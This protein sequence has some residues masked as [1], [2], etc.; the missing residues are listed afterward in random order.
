MIVVVKNQNQIL[1]AY[2]QSSIMDYK[3]MSVIL[4]LMVN[5]CSH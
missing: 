5:S 4:Q 3:I 1:Q 2:F